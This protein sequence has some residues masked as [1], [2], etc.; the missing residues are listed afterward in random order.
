MEKKDVR[1]ELPKVQASSLVEVRK[2][3]E[4]KFDVKNLEFTNKEEKKRRN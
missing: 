4:P 1:R 3:E 2:G